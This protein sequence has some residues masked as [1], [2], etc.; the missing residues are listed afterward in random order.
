MDLTWDEGSYHGPVTLVSVGNNPRTGGVFY[1]VPNADPFDGRLS[2]VYGS[3]PT[4]SEI[5]RILPRTMQPGEGNYTQH[6]AVNE[7]HT[8]WLKIRTQPA[9]PLHTDGELIDMAT[10]TLEYRV[11]PERIPILIP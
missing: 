9:T 1:T 10:H 8:K 3:V 11:H 5:L 2:F 6:P 7:I 4:R